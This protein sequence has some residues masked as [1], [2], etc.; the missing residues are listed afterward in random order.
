MANYDSTMTLN[1]F[2]GNVQRAGLGPERHSDDAKASR[3]LG[4]FFN[5][6][7]AANAHD[8][9]SLK[10]ERRNQKISK[11]ELKAYK[12]KNAKKKEAKKRAWLTS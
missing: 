5:I 8:G 7:D 2:T 4:N 12:E 3:Q 1:R 10:E 9:R 6:D 11:K